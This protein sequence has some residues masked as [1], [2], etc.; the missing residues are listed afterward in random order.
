[1]EGRTET[2][3]GSNLVRPTRRHRALPTRRS[4]ILPRLALGL[5]AA[6]WLVLAL[7]AV[8]VPRRASAYAPQLAD[9][10]RR[11]PASYFHHVFDPDR[12]LD[13]SAG[14]D[15][16]LD[17]LQ[18]TT[19][20]QVVLG[21][22]K[23]L[24][25]GDPLFT[26]ELAQQWRVGGPTYNGLLLFVFPEDRQIRADVG[27][28]LEDLL[29]DATMRRILA[30][31]LVPQLQRGDYPGGLTAALRQLSEILAS[32]SALASPAPGP[33]TYLRALV[34]D[35]PGVARSA[36]DHWRR[37]PL[38]RRLVLNLLVVLL[39]AGAVTV[40][41]VVPQVLV[42]CGRS[43]VHLARGNGREAVNVAG[44]LYLMLQWAAGAGVIL[45]AASIALNT[46]I[47]GTGRF[48]GGGVE[49]SW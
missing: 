28:G 47:G 24:P 4:P 8:V 30:D 46:Y 22:L 40:G 33:S 9:L 35:V 1:M 45:I 17:I 5:A 14:L 39:A 25:A 29:P 15:S 6:A 34:A 43:C 31:N 20:H 21:A 32:R 11:G 48:G 18:H 41:I 19:G 44:G 13:E 10:L 7:A 38:G 42:A 3:R 37:A 36:M 23:R 49:L 16:Q 2:R 27:Y 12:L 26:T